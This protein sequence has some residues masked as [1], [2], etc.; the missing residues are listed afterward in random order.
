MLDPVGGPGTVPTPGPGPVQSDCDPDT[1]YFERDLLP[2]FVSN[3]A[4]SGC[5][6]TETDA[7]KDVQLTDYDNIRKH[8]EPGDPE[9]SDIYEMITEEDADDRMP[10]GGPP[11]ASNQIQLIKKWIEQGAQNLHCED[12]TC[13]TSNV[14]FAATV[15]PIFHQT[16]V[17]CH[18]A[19]TANAG[20]DFSTYAGVNA[21]INAGKLMGA[22]NHESGF[23]PMPQ[24][25]NKLDQCKIDQIR[26]WIDAG[27]LEN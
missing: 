22:I 23:K 5:H 9:G 8:V 26:I 17:G 20:F 24:N 21:S 11:L 19:T 25:G 10:K 27:A 14:T 13:D 1:V 7:N 4:M 16:C 18:N 15:H 2:I 3:C 12:S 6:N